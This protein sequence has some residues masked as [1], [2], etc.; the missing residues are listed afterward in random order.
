MDNYLT[1]REALGKF[2]DELIKRKPVPVNS[3]EELS[4]WRE[5]QIKLL[6]DRIAEAIFSKL[7]EDQLIALNQIL[8]RGEES[9][10][11]FQQFFQNA[12]LDLAKIIEDTIQAYSLEYF[13]G[14]PADPISNTPAERNNYG[15]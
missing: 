12:H 3:T 6:D 4:T 7:S 5:A 2:I 14:T 15:E 10:E 13:K 8:D 11:V 9:P 1:D